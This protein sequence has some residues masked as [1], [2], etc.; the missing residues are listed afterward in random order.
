MAMD[1]QTRQELVNIA[2]SLEAIWM[3]LQTQPDKRSGIDLLKQHAES[4]KELAAAE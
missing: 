3:Q 2:A 4:L 1:E